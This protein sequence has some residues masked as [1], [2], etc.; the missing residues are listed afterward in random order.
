M[1]TITC[2]LLF[3]GTCLAGLGTLAFLAAV[4]AAPD[5]ETLRLA[6]LAAR[7]G[8]RIAIPG[9]ALW[10]ISWPTAAAPYT[11]LLA[12]ALTAAT[13]SCF[14]TRAAPELIRRAAT[15]SL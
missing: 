10:L 15:W 8:R 5:P 11:L 7:V 2:A 13:A 14:V 4:P 6:Y 9:L 3:L 12:V 1:T